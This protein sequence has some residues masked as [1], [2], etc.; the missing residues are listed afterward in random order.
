[1]Q[2]F[3]L[4]YDYVENAVERRVPHRDAHLK[5]ARDAH[6]KGLLLMG[7]AFADPVDGAALLFRAD[8]R[9]EVEA[10]V[11][12]DPYVKNGVVTGFRIRPWTVVIGG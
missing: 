7:G 1:V 11:S 2:H 4:L 3:L 12:R 9:E 10:F 8:A 5:L 6:E